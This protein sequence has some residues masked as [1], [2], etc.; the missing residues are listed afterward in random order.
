M[1]AR[2]SRFMKQIVS[3]P[4]VGQVSNLWADFQ[5]AVLG[6]PD[7]PDYDCAP[8]GRSASGGQDGTVGG[9]IGHLNA[10]RIPPGRLRSRFF[11][12]PADAGRPTA[13]MNG[14]PHLV[15]IRT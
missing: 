7:N 4:T 5:A 11:A 1:S 2:T 8:L 6:F 9:T 3:Q 10:R 12:H 13:A 15:T 14:W